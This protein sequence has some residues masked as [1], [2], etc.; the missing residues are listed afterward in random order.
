LHIVYI[1]RLLFFL[2]LLTSKVLATY[3]QYLF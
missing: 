3:Y 2:F 1:D